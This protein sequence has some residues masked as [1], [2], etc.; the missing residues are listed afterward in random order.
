MD[1]PTFLEFWAKMAKITLKVKV[2]NPYFQQQLTVFGAKP[3]R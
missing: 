3:V 1:K 2:N